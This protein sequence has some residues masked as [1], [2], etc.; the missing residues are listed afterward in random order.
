[1]R[2]FSVTAG[3]LFSALACL[4]LSGCGGAASY[5]TP[6]AAFKGMQ[7]AAEKEDWKAFCET[8]T[9][10]SRDMMAGSMAFGGMFMSKM[11]ALGAKEEDKAKLKTID[12]VLKKHGLT[13]EHFSKLPKDP[14]PKDKAGQQAAMRKMVEPVKDKAAFVGD[15]MKSMKSL[16]KDG[17]SNFSM[18]KSAKLEELKVEGDTA[19]GVIV[20]QI[21]G[22]DKREP[23][24]FRK[25]SG[26]WRVELLPTN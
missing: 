8:L 9:D 24:E 18:I 26:S 16:S 21:K 4:V 2:S 10:D 19:K 25:V 11:G 17:E 20:T 22:Q 6:D 13:E 5:S 23:V 1:M 3:A 12:E 14:M 15:M 7:T